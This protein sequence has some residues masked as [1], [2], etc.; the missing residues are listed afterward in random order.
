MSGILLQFNT[1]GTEIDRNIFNKMFSVLEHRGSDGS[2]VEFLNNIALGHHHFWTTPEEVNEVQPLKRKSRNCY[3]LFDGRLDNRD[4]LFSLYKI[5]KN[6]ISDAKLILEL[7]SRFD[8]EF[9]KNLVGSYVF[10]IYDK[11]K[12]RIITVRDH[13]GD[14]ILYYY[15]DRKK[16]IIASEPISI[17]NNPDIPIEFNNKKV[18]EFFAVHEQT[19]SNSFF[20]NI[21]EILPAHYMIFDKSEI[22]S[23]RYWDLDPDKKIRYKNEE[24]YFEHFRTLF[25]KTVECRLRTIDDPGI[26]MSGGFDSTSIAAY[27]ANIYKNENKLKTFTYVFDK[28]KESDER[29]YINDFCQMHDVESIQVNGDDRWPLN[30]FDSWI[31]NPNF[32]YL[33]PYQGLKLKLFDSVKE[34]NIKTL[35]IG[36]YADQLFT[37]ADYWLKDY[38]SDLKFLT[39]TRK[40]VNLINTIGIRNIS[41][42]NPLRI[43]L[44]P[45][46]YIRDFVISKPAAELEYNFLTADSKSMLSNNGYW[47]DFTKN[48]YRADQ[49]INVAGLN[50]ASDASACSY[51]CNGSLLDYRYPFR[52]R[53]LVEFFFQLPSYQIYDNSGYKDKYILRNALKKHLPDSILK[54]SKTT[55]FEGLLFYGLLEKNI[56]LIRNIIEENS[57]ELE[58]FIHVN[59]L[60]EVL[61]RNSKELPTDDFFIFWNSLSFILWKNKLKEFQL[62]H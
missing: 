17:L 18:A 11:P 39:A 58:P 4:E 28:F 15:Y 29:K 57:C 56:G 44:R 41:K 31:V 53:R 34:H 35:L 19:D 32:P 13:L 42:N 26:M 3:I 6:S 7:Y 46:K 54:R 23:V 43:A 61:Y 60:K 8:N 59:K 33:N 37:G 47:S 48:Y 9:F 1:D 27:A 10:V 25:Y 20:K 40:T 21:Y 51:C 22:K 2:R 36:W 50:T 49:A 38:L 5:S 30:Y 45:L 55:S 16:L 14:K 24:K 12:N 52:D 62:N